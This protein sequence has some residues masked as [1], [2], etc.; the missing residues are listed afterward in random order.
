MK[1]SE[2]KGWYF[3][4]YKP[5]D[6]DELQA[7]VSFNK[8]NDPDCIVDFFFPEQYEEISRLFRQ[9]LSED[10]WNEEMENVFSIPQSSV[11]AVGNTLRAAGLTVFE[12]SFGETLYKGLDAGVLLASKRDGGLSYAVVSLLYGTSQ[13]EGTSKQSALRDLLTDVRHAADYLGLNFDDAVKC[14][15]NVFDAEKHEADI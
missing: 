12:V 1:A 10:E 9:V 7:V 13:R 11:L 14:S 3:A 8:T 4:I 2:L 6:D 15:E 5:E